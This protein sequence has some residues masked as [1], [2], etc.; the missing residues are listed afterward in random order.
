MSSLLRVV[1]AAIVIAIAGCAGPTYTVEMEA[2]GTKVLKGF[3]H[4]EDM[5]RDPLF[6][7]YSANYHSYPLD[8]ATVE[9]LKPLVDDVHFVM[10]LGTWCGDSKR[11]V[12]H[13]C[14]V[15]DAAGVKESAVKYFGVDRTKKSGDGTTDTYN[16][17]RVPTI[18]VFRGEQELGR[19]VEHP[20]E[21]L[22]KDLL[23]LL[24]R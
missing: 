5:E 2:S 8:S 16:V 13:C 3:F 21:S 15:F 9:S 19:I 7:W 10:V 20:R 22:E 18:I 11:E 6:S 4:R 12:P 24:Q 17:A 14:R 1:L 23:R